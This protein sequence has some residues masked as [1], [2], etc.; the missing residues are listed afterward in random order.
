[1]AVEPRIMIR[2]KN[3]L[4]WP[5]DIFRRR[6]EPENSGPRDGTGKGQVADQA[7]GVLQVLCGCSLWRK[8][9]RGWPSL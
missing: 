3:G 2:V 7:A 9:T 1:M 8:Y 4:G 6:S 5:Q